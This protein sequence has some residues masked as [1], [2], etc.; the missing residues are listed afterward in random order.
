MYI[1]MYVCVCACVRVCVCVCVC[2]YIYIYI[3]IESPRVS[4][5][6]Y[7]YREREIDRYTIPKVYIRS[8]RCEKVSNDGVRL[9]SAGETEGP[10]FSA[11]LNSSFGSC[12]IMLLTK[13]YA[14]N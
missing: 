2:I 12:I 7:I 1:R 3:Y 8:L 14:P 9:A 10:E 11:P 4:A 5:G 13:P 6:V